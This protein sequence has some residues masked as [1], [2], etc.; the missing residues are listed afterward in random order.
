VGFC[1]SIF[2]D[3]T[4]SS[5]PVTDNVVTLKYT[6]VNSRLMVKS[7]PVPLNYMDGIEIC[8]P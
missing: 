8:L 4:L 1:I 5:C 3:V 7:I 6:P 2:D